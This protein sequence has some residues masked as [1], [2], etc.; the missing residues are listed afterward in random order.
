VA[1]CFLGHGAFGFLIKKAW[2]PFFGVV[3]IAPAEAVRLMPLVGLMDVSLGIATLIFP[4]RFIFLHLTLWGLWTAALRPLS[5]Q[6]FWE[7]IERAGNYG[8][9]LA[10]LVLVGFPQR[11]RDWFTHLAKD[12]VPAPG[13]KSIHSAEWILRATITLLLV[14]H[15][16]LNLMSKPGLIEH[17]ESIRWADTTIGG[18]GIATI[19][20][21]FEIALAML[22]LLGGARVLLGVF[23][24][25]MLSEALYI[26]AGSLPLEWIERAGSYAA[27]LAL[28]C[29]PSFNVHP[30]RRAEPARSAVPHPH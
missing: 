14:G 29:L 5:G 11:F 2:I 12:S 18:L 24:W 23:V 25:K 13:S 8:V 20:G 22:T 1:G 9:P 27:P 30:K 7:M 3:G 21:C 19:V 6:P 10:L 15:G 4:M 17:Y 16:A 28:Y 26:T